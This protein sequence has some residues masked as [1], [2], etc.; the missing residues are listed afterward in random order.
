MCTGGGSR[1]CAARATTAPT[2][3][4]PRGLLRSK[5]VGVDELLL[6]D[7]FGAAE[8]RRALD[9]ADLVI[10]AMYGTGFRGRLEGTAEMVVHGL[11]ASPVPVLAVDIPSGVDGT[12]GEIAGAAVQA[13][14]TIC[15]AALKTGL[16]FEPG[17]AHAGAVTVADIGIAVGDAG[18]RPDLAVLDVTDLVLPSRDAAA[19]KWSAGCLVVGGSGGMVGAPML[20]GQA[21]LHCGAGMVVC[22][23]PGS[24]AAAQVSGRELVAHALAATPDGRVRRG[25]GRRGAERGAP[26]PIARAGSGLGRAEPARAA[27]RRIVAEAN[28]AMVIDA[29]ALNALAADPSALDA[30]HAAGLP[31]AVLTP[32][33]AEYERARGPAGRHRSGGSGA[34][35]RPAV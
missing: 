35:P 22:A 4:S 24:D 14:H 11:D 15:L 20:A 2:V 25:R 29:D 23:V 16:L 1:S 26:V 10:D 9:R 31:V 13:A 7:D 5:G 18:A 33:A 30:R 3:A 12:T 27:A 21:A 8:L 32:H 6:A 19:H 17:R 34:G 28:V